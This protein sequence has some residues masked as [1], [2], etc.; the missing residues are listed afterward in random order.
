MAQH[1]A[2]MLQMLNMEIANTEADHKIGNYNND[3]VPSRGNTLRN[4]M[5]HDRR[6]TNEVDQFASTLKTMQGGYKVGH[7]NLMFIENQVTAISNSVLNRSLNN[8]AQ[9]IAERKNREFDISKKL[10]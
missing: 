7:S 9:E 1:N 3:Q 8:S 6:D 5:F 2:T 10:K 4:S